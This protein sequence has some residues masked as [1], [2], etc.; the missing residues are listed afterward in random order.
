[1]ER[2]EITVKLPERNEEKKNFMN[3]RDEDLATLG[4]E[5]LERIRKAKE[6]LR[7][8][9]KTDLEVKAMVT[10]EQMEERI[11]EYMAAHGLS[12]EDAEMLA[13]RDFGAL[14]RSEVGP[15][16]VQPNEDPVTKML[17]EALADRLKVI[18]FPEPGA[19]TP[20][21]GPPGGPGGVGGQAAPPISEAIKAAKEHGVK[22]LYLP[23][24]TILAINPSDT[25][26]DELVKETMGWLKEKVPMLFSS[27]DK[28]S[29]GL[30]AS[31]S[32]DIV[33]VG[34]EFRAAEKEAE[35]AQTLAQARV[36]MGKDI[37]AAIGM[38]FSPEGFKK[39]QE[40][41]G[42]FRE[43]VAEHGGLGGGPPMSNIGCDE[44]H[45]I[46]QVPQGAPTFTCK[47]CGTENAVTWE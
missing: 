46:N 3:L 31:Q 29:E 21:G 35:A 13:K 8:I 26:G 34:L 24:G 39:A 16:N 23:D 40:M 38:L 43:A 36:T 18:L 47:K 41:I 17:K 28:L 2:G 37:A 14:R 42:G 33:R 27:G 1:M 30:L 11:N 7:E 12:R 5:E 44:C 19:G 4:S 9:K 32:P 20:A 6:N 45:T 22:T 10:Q 25:L 15:L